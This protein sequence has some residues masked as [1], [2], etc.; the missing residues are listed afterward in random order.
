MTNETHHPHPTGNASV[1]EWSQEITELAN[2]LMTGESVTLTAVQT[3]LLHEALRRSAADQI[4]IAK[5]QRRLERYA[6]SAEDLEMQAN[7]IINRLMKRADG[8]AV[9][10]GFSYEDVRRVRQ[11]VAQSIERAG[12]GADILVAVLTAAMRVFPTL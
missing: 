5:L 11:E 7:A 10:D 1:D 4:H 2:Q 6:R 8:P 12:N 3:K 9:D